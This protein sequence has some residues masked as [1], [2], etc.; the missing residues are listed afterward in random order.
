MVILYTKNGCI[1]C[2]QTKKRLEKMAIAYREVNIE[3]DLAALA[4]LKVEGW[5]S[6]PVVKTPTSSWSGF[7]PEKIDLL[8]NKT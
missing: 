3:E 2:K 8:R 5:L 7:N 6:M 4:A 1:A